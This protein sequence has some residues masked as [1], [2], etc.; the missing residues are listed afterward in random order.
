ML[1][2][3]ILNYIAWNQSLEC[4][5]S[6]RQSQREEDYRIILI[7]NASPTRMPDD[8]KEM[9][10]KKEIEYLATE[11]NI[12]FARGNNLGIRLAKEK[13]CDYILLTNSDIRFYKGAIDEM[14]HCLKKDKTVGIVGPMIYTPEGDIQKTNLM[15]KTTMCDKWMVRTIARKLFKSA[16]D[17]YY[18]LNLD[19]KTTK[20]VY[21]VNGCCFMLSPLFLER[22][23]ELDENT[24]LYEEELILGITMERVGLKT[25]YD[26]QAEVVHY[27]KQS[28]Q[29]VVPFSFLCLS[30][31]E[32]YYCSK[33]LGAKHIEVYLLYFY[34]TLIYLIHGI[35][36]KEFMG[37]A[38][39][40][41]KRETNIY[42][43]KFVRKR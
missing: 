13:K 24:V 4:I 5:Q 17:K 40:N 25:I 30:C 41:Y 7:D 20:T 3:V 31:S 12:G 10:E 38:W 36:H 43:R 33:C 37:T 23:G 16:T 18:G 6:I 34:R 39:K 14:L 1:G 19:Y 11:T 26:A 22:L 2:I 15:K 32:I 8:I 28:S 29:H 9:I 27:H 21:A 35:R 42:L